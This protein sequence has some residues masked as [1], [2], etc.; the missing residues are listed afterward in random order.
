MEPL[1]GEALSW[2]LQRRLSLVMLSLLVENGTQK[3][4]TDYS[5]LQS[6]AGDKPH[7]SGTSF[8]E[9]SK[10]EDVAS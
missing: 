7:S 6:Q 9:N 3:E 10:E 5:K 2:V 8:S 4:R 1:F